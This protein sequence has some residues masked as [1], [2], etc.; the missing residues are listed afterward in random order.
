[1]KTGHS[2][3]V[4]MNMGREG[5][6]PDNGD[7]TGGKRGD[8]A[9]TAKRPVE[10]VKHAAVSV[11]IITRDRRDQL[12][13][14][15][16]RLSSLREKPPIIV[17]DNGSS[18]GTRDMVRIRF[19]SVRLLHQRHNLGSAART[20]GVL[21]ADTPYVAFS[22]DDSWWARGALTKAVRIFEEYPRLGLIAAKVLVGPDEHV[23]PVCEMMAE[24]PLPARDELPG[25]PVLGFVACGAIVRREAYLD[26]EGFHERFMV[27]GEEELFAMD[28]RAAGWQL[29]YV[30]EIVANHFPA[31]GP[32]RAGRRRR[33]LRNGLWAAWL[34]LPTVVAMKRSADLLHSAVGDRE[35]WLGAWDAARGLPWIVRQR[36][37]LPP[38]VVSD[39][40][41][42]AQ[43]S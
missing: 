37:Q 1:M 5:V 25:P 22:D 10:K 43:L 4:C 13:V 17:I 16:S 38:D 7:R 9:K 20:L 35:M 12:A 39:V 11:V 8:Y 41:L 27:G 3:T 14:T 29:A 33:E 19:P 21:A 40:E 34:R 24:S 23:D 32:E 28:L 42:L 30:D 2:N 36:K 26:V 31:P 6:A 18:D 15:L